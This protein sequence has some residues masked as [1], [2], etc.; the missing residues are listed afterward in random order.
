LAQLTIDGHPELK[1]DK[2]MEKI[3]KNDKKGTI[4]V[5]DSHFMMGHMGKKAERSY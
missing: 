4:D 3:N 1:D 2:Q 5:N